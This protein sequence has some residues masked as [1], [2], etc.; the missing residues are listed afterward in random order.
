MTLRL[1]P[2]QVGTGSYDIDGQLVF[3][4]GLLAAVLVRLSGYHDDMSGMWFLEAGFGL[5][6]T[7]NRPTFADLDTAQTWIEPQLAQAA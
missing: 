3:A 6:D 1:Q 5:V 7:P 4:D 2:V